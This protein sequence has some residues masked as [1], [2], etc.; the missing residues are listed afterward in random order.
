[1]SDSEIRATWVEGEGYHV[2]GNCSD[3][4]VVKLLLRG[5]SSHPGC[6]RHEDGRITHCGW[7]GGLNEYYCSQCGKFVCRR[8]HRIWFGAAEEQPDRAEYYG[9]D[10]IKVEY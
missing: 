6:V 4:G 2:E 9:P 1:M 10:K 7:G 5:S 3:C 8:D